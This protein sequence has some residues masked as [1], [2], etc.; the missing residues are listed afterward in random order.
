MAS[1]L[2]IPESNIAGVVGTAIGQITGTIV[3]TGNKALDVVELLL[4]DTR[5]QG[6]FIQKQIRSIQD[7][8]LQEASVLQHE[9]T[10]AS[11]QEVGSAY[12]AFLK[13]TTKSR[14]KVSEAVSSAVGNLVVRVD[15]STAPLDSMLQAKIQKEVSTLLD[16][17]SKQVTSLVNEYNK[18]VKRVSKQVNTTLGIIEASLTVIITAI[19]TLRAI[20][21]T[22]KIPVAALKA[23]ILIIKMIPLP[24]RYL[25]VS[26]TILESD[27]LEMMTELVTQVDEIINA[28]EKVL[29]GIIAALTPL[30][31][32][33]RRIRAMLSM[34]EANNL[35]LNASPSDIDALDRAGLYDKNSGQSLFDIIQN[36]QQNNS[37]W[38]IYGRPGG[39]QGGNR[40]S[41]SGTGD[42]SGIYESENP[43]GRLGGG[44]G[45]ATRPSSSIY[46]EWGG[47]SY[48]VDLTDPRIGNQL[49]LANPGDYIRYQSNTSGSYMEDYYKWNPD[50]PSYPTGRPEDE[51]WSRYPNEPNLDQQ[52]YSLWH[53]RTLE[54]GD[55]GIY[56]GFSG[57]WE[58]TEVKDWKDL[59]DTFG[60]F[61]DFL[62]GK[63]SVSGSQG[64]TYDPL[65]G[66]SYEDGILVLGEENF[67]QKPGI[68][69]PSSWD[70]LEIAALNK[71]R[72]IPLSTDL[73]DSLTNLWQ[74]LAAEEAGTSTV[75]DD[76][77]AYRAAN[78]ELYYLRVLEDEHSPRVAVRRYVQVK[79]ESG[80][81][82]LEGTKTFSLNKES[83][84]TEMKLQLDQMTR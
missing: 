27:L 23:A 15:I 35:L 52:G 38:E 1:Y 16:R 26:F 31:D 82:I 10:Q 43:Y 14:E 61:K 69:K 83:L 9:L 68:L 40:P 70:A 72:D 54:T 41:G 81:V 6:Q 13:K 5:R 30:R 47:R 4:G 67:D 24:Q 11:Q 42:G 55:G 36:G 71:L 2:R 77:V 66:W 39:G 18:L 12:E 59:L 19:E 73:R 75:T 58:A 46:D 8:A 7:K 22:L 56:S 78:G 60:K 49:Q 51:G 34:F 74:T 57:S 65:R 25:I 76:A 63:M 20:I 64:W 3:S 33:I 84:I 17:A 53:I 79:D 62:T 37:N 50:Q 29:A 80:T 45:G 21:L 48:E 32:R 44:Q 28:I